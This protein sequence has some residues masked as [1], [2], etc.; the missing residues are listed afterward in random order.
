MLYQSF[1]LLHYNYY[2]TCILN[3]PYNKAQNTVWIH[4]V[5]ER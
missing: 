4:V 3:T 1:D 2:I 5:S